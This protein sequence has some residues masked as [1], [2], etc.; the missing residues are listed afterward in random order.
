MLADGE[1]IET[2]FIGERRLLEQL[3][4]A[5]LGGDARGEVGKGRESKFHDVVEDSR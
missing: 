3:A 2:E 1:H 4:H 5:L